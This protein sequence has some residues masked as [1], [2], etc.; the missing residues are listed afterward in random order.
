MRLWIVAL[1]VLL[2]P[3]GLVIWAV[4]SRGKTGDATHL[5]V[6]AQN[7]ASAVSYLA[8]VESTMACANRTVRS[9]ALLRVGR[10]GKRRIDYIS[11]DLRGFKSGCDGAVSW[12]YDV[13]NGKVFVAPVFH[14]ERGVEALT[15]NHEVFLEGDDKV[16]GRRAHVVAIR[17]RRSGAVVRRQWL[18]YEHYIPLKTETY[19]SDGRLVSRTS[20]TSISFI[21]QDGARFSPPRIPGVQVVGE[22]SSLVPCSS[23]SELRKA[24]G[25]AVATPKYI[26]EGFRPVGYYYCVCPC[27]R[28][29]APAVRYGNG[30]KSFT[31]FQCER[32]CKSLPDGIVR[33]FGGVSLA[34]AGV[35]GVRVVVIGELEPSEMRRVALSASPR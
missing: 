18:D 26:P 22:V 5:L 30:V 31:V 23:A 28:N 6:R 15:K 33:D 2:V 14:G 24:V 4:K 12:R 9:R 21:P 19:D 16:A 35:S 27:C 13:S 34:A 7:A 25:H 29:V 17:E 1:C 3:A 20:V 32:G 11:G 10:G 8:T